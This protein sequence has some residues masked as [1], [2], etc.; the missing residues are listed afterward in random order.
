MTIA[1]LPGTE[2]GFQRDWV[3][4]FWAELSGRLLM[5]CPLSLCVT[6]NLDQAWTSPEFPDPCLLECLPWMGSSYLQDGVW[7]QLSS[8]TCILHG[9]SPIS[10]PPQGCGLLQQTATNPLS[11]LVQ[12]PLSSLI[13][14]C[15]PMLSC[16]APVK[17]LAGLSPPAF[18]AFGGLQLPGLGL[19]PASGQPRALSCFS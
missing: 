14:L 10:V 18:P 1:H 11:S 8:L 19:L 4:L 6:W 16:W 13:D 9:F 12:S 17:T 2:I 3:F 5:T 15:D 7:P